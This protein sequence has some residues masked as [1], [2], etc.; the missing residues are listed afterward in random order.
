LIDE[1]AAKERVLYEGL[2]RE[3]EAGGVRSEELSEAVTLSYPGNSEQLA[4]VL[5][6]AGC[7]LEPFGIDMVKFTHVP[8][9][10]SAMDVKSILASL[11]AEELNNR[12]E[13]DEEKTEFLMKR[14]VHH[15]SLT[16]T[17][18]S[19]R[20]AQNQLISELQACQSPRQTP[21]GHATMIHLSLDFMSRQFGR[22]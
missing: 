19:E 12:F 3:V 11:L 6:P 14:L 4:A 17:S 18:G 20:A 9:L 22:G 2:L 15:A 13:V 16:F 8:A 10:L 21:D 7:S 5:R 1:K